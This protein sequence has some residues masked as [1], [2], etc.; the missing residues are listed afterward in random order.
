MHAWSRTSSTTE[1]QRNTHM[2]WWVDRTRPVGSIP[3]YS[4]PVRRMEFLLDVICEY[5]Q[6]EKKLFDTIYAPA[7]SR[8][9]STTE[10]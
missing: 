10:F 8:T 3:T 5:S 6:L 7:G 4:R 2:L 9:P 1:S